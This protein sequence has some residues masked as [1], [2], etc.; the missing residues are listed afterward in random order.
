MSNIIPMSG[1]CLVEDQNDNELASGF[2]VAKE[3][4]NQSQVGKVI[5]LPDDNVVDNVT[6]EK[7]RITVQD[8]YES[9]TFK[10]AKLGSFIIYKKYGG[11]E[12]ELNGKKYRLV[13][14]SEII[15]IIK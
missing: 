9:Q 15:G 5:A 10:L 6:L 13:A 3:E 1:Y 7:L 2:V 11:N 4:K 14:Y 12:V 8:L